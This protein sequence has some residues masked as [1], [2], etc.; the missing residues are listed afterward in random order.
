MPPKTSQS[1]LR[2]SETNRTL[3]YRAGLI[4]LHHDLHRVRQQPHPKR[5]GDRLRGRCINPCRAADDRRRDRHAGTGGHGRGRGRRSEDRSTVRRNTRVR[6]PDRSSPDGRKDRRADATTDAIH[7]HG[8]HH[9]P[10]GLWAGGARQPEGWQA[11]RAPGRSI[12]R[13]RSR[14]PQAPQLELVT[15]RNSLFQVRTAL[16]ENEMPAAE[17]RDEATTPGSTFPA[18]TD[19]LRKAVDPDS[20]A[21]DPFT[22]A[23]R[24]S[25]RTP[26]T[27]PAGGTMPGRARCRC[28][29]PHAPEPARATP[30]ALIRKGSRTRSLVRCAVILLLAALVLPVASARVDAQAG[31]ETPALADPRKTIP[32]KM[33]PGATTGSSQGD[34]SLSERLGRSDGVIAPQSDTDLRMSV[35]A[36]VPDPGTTPVIPPPGSPG[37]P[38]P[39]RPK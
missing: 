5:A 7:T 31:T 26:G 24:R 20:L 12:R 16:H 22:C 27:L 32:E 33:E 11:G 29:A 21:Q 17:F 30:L 1:T 4:G 3:R 19:A 36:P 38:S 13:P 18:P 14:R 2:S 9:G 39:V 35:P 25:A 28:M 34:G 6:I 15:S 23:A 37:N 10:S 8:V